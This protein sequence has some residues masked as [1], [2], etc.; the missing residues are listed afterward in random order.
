MVLIAIMATALVA[1]LMIQESA[2]AGVVFPP[3]PG[4]CLGGPTLCP[5][6]SS[7]NSGP[8]GTAYTD[9]ASFTFSSSDGGSMFR[10]SLDGAPFGACRSPPDEPHEANY[11]GLSEGPHTFAVRSKN[12]AGT[13][14]TA[15]SRTWTVDA[16]APSALITNPAEGSYDNDGFFTVS[17]TAE[18][19][20]T[21]VL[22]E[23][24]ASKGTTTADGAGNWS[25]VLAGVTE[26]SHSYRAKATDRAGNESAES[27]PRTVIVDITKT[28]VGSISPTTDAKDVPLTANVRMAFSEDVDPSSISNQTFSLLKEGSSFSNPVAA[29][30][31]YDRTTKTATLVPDSPLEANTSYWAFIQGEGAQVKDLAGNALARPYVWRFTTASPLLA[32]LPTVVDYTPTQTTD[33]P[34]KVR[35]TATFSTDMKAS[36]ITAINIKFQ[37]YSKMKKEWVSVANTVSYDATI[38]TA[39]ITPYS[40]LA[41]S[42]R[43]RVT[44]T[45]NVKSSTSVALDQD[46]TTAGNQPKRWTFTT[47][48]S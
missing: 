39:T 27:A 13:T 32:P 19:N 22:S 24:T 36:T 31:S 1:T 12:S 10:C 25:I 33:V 30:I 18:A 35:P 44:I 42:K 38:R 11:S 4:I 47:A 21:V 9:W 17:G 5:P 14:G 2:E 20:S 16:T 6:E 40:T 7:I 41:T 48:S 28:T 34:R 26:G 15:A 29:H 43:Y 45:T 3:E 46:A 37:V 8:S 23:G